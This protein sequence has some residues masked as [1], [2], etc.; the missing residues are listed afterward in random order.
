MFVFNRCSTVKRF[1]SYGYVEMKDGRQ[2][3]ARRINF[4]VAYVYM[5][6]GGEVEA[7]GL[8]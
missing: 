7:I 2:I 1:V 6:N 5:Y 3:E 8:N 4:R